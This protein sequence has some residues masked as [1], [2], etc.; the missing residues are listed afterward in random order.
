[1]LG[2]RAS[3]PV[4]SSAEIDRSTA[5]AYFPALDGL[6]AIAFMMVFATHYLQLPWGEQA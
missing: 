4:S 1:V 2:S 5:G 3:D 6:R